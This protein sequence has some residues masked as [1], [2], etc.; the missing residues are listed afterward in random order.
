MY[1]LELYF[2][3]QSVEVGSLAEIEWVVMKWVWCDPEHFESNQNPQT[4][5]ETDNKSTINVHRCLCGREK[6]GVTGPP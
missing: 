5:R 6:K 4:D 3:S 1:E 2:W